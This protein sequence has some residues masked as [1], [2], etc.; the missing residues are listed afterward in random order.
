MADRLEPAWRWCPEYTLTYGPIV[1]DLAALAGF[2]PDPEQEDAL[3]EI[4]AID[5]ASGVVTTAAALD[6]EA[7]ASHGIVVRA[8]SSDTSFSTK[9]FTIAVN[10]VDEFDGRGMLVVVVD[11]GGVMRRPFDVDDVVVVEL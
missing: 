1:A 11:D 2:A 9:A 6:R 7:A 5:P 10:D 3:N 8:T 4:F